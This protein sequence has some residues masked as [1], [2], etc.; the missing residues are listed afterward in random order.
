MHCW[1]NLNCCGCASTHAHVRRRRGDG[2][3]AG[4]RAVGNVAFGFEVGRCF[5]WAIDPYYFCRSHC[6]RSEQ[7][8]QGAGEKLLPVAQHQRLQK[9]ERAVSELYD[10]RGPLVLFNLERVGI[11]QV[12]FGWRLGRYL[13]SLTGSACPPGSQWWR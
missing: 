9:H 11:Q 6:A 13:S 7:Y 10:D 4:V 1:M 2:G 5:G 3:C 12:D 8:I